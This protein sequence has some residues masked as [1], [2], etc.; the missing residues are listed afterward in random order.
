MTIDINKFY[1]LL[2][3]NKILIVDAS[4]SNCKLN[5]GLLMRAGYEAVVTV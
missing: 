1:F 2:M 4:D 3:M 5:S